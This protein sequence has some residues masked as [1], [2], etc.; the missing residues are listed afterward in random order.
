VSLLD[1]SKITHST[2]LHGTPS[3]DADMVSFELDGHPFMAISAGP[4]FKPNPSISFGLFFD[5]EKHPDAK[6]RL[7]A[8]WE[9][10]SAGGEI[11]M[12]LQ[13]YPFSTWYGWTDDKY[14]FSWQLMLTEEGTART[15]VLPSFM[16]IGPNAGRA[17]EAINFYCSVFKDGKLGSLQR[18]DADAGADAGTVIHAEFCL[19]NTWFTAMDSAGPHEFAF[20]E[21][22]SFIV[23]CDTQE[24]IDYYW[25]H[26][27]AVPEAE[28]CGWLKDTFGVSW[29]IVPADMG[30]MLGEGTPEQIERVTKAFLAMKKFD[31]AALRAAYEGA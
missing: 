1:N 4:V 31:V 19:R 17:E 11:R 29:Q 15:S 24:E 3:G 21:A 9:K 30:K 13:E 25:E 23:Q 20:N 26:L 14:G 22:V 10:L 12:P 2:A 16:F 7:T 27:S 6:E 18:Y 8:A 5:P 28:Q